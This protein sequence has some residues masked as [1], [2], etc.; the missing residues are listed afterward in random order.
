[1][2]NPSDQSYSYSVIVNLDPAT[3]LKVM[4]SPTKLMIPRT[5]GVLEKR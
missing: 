4:E 5:V 2:P 3:M 1:M